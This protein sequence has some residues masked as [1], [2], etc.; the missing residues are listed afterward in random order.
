MG[1]LPCSNDLSMRETFS[2]CHRTVWTA[3]S[4]EEL[5]EFCE[6]LGYLVE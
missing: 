4:V 3:L 5:V 6:N 1:K 2:L